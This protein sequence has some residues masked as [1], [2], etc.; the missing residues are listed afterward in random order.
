[1]RAKGQVLGT[2]MTP[3]KIYKY[4]RERLRQHLD[5]VG[6]TPSYLARLCKWSTTSYVSQMLGP[7][8]TRYLTEPVARR[9]EKCLRLPQGYLDQG[10]EH[11]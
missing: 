3:L 6:I 11:G 5:N 4:R 7:S 2:R 1:M 8:P 9:I 10:Y